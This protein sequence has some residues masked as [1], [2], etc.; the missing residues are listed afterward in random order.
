MDIRKRMAHLNKEIKLYIDNIGIYIKYQLVTKAILFVLVVPAFYKLADLFIKSSGEIVLSSGNYKTF[1]SSLPMIGFLIGALILFLLVVVIDINAFIAIGYNIKKTG[2]TISVIQ[3]LKE[4]LKSAKSFFSPAGAFLLL[5]TMLIVPLV[6]VGL[7]TSV[8]ESLKIPNFITSFVYDNPLYLLIYSIVMILLAIVGFFL[9]L[10]FHYMYLNRDGVIKAVKNSIKTIWKKKSSM[11][12]NLILV[13]V[14]L[15]LV[16][17]ISLTIMYFMIEFVDHV[18]LGNVFINRFV[19]MFLLFMFTEV[20]NL[21]FFLIW[22]LQIHMLTSAFCEETENNKVCDVKNN[23]VYR[24]MIVQNRKKLVLLVTILMIFNLLGSG[25][26]A[27]AFDGLFHYYPNIEIVAHRGGGN[28]GAENTIIGLNEAVK[29]GAKWS[30]IDVMRS[31]DGVYVINHDN[32]FKRLAGND[33]KPSEMTWQEIQQLQIKDTFNPERA[34][35]AVADLATMMDT[36]KGKIGLLIELKGV[37]ADQK[38][39]DDVVRAIIDRQMKDEAI[40]ISLDYN[41]IKYIEEK[42]PYINTGYLYFFS[43]GDPSKINTDYLMMEE[44]AVNADIINK[45]HSEGKKAFV[46]TVNDPEAIGDLMLNDVDGIITDNVVELKD[47][48]KKMDHKTDK[49]VILD[50]LKRLFKNN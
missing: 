17:D 5:Y 23:I 4:G 1:L 18:S 39:A 22:P 37:D 10:S 50:E 11:I 15:A 45:I 13:N 12:V 43:L 29:V 26:T 49:D 19:M 36:A 24:Q 30:E 25:I 21:W 47:A 34:S 9:L 42:Y 27:F 14:M 46:W 2:K 28:L 20:F 40:I 16:A 41:I 32:T 38:M 7:K 35:G 48:I 3:A 44:S 6:G 33:K 8:F 31:K